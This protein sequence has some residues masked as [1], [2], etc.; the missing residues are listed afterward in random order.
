MGRHERILGLPIARFNE[1]DLIRLIKE[2]FG[3]SPASLGIGDDCCALRPRAGYDLLLTTDTLAEGV[4]FDRSYSSA[5][6]LGRK[7]VAVNLSDIAAMGGKP[8]YLLLSLNLTSD[9]DK[10]W[11]GK[12]LRGFESA[13][14]PF[15]TSLI[16]GN[17]TSA[18]NDL[19]FTVTAIGEVKRGKRVD[20]SGAKV[21]DFIYVTGTVGDSAVGLDILQRGSTK[22]NALEKRLITR[23]LEPTPRIEWGY[24]LGDKKLVSSMID[25][26]DGLAL[27]LSRLIDASSAGAEI[28]LEAI[29][30]SKDL[31]VSSEGELPW[32]R[33]L[34]GGEDY[35]LLFTVR[36]SA[37][38]EVEHLI[39]RGMLT[40]VSIGRV[41]KPPSG[42]NRVKIIDSSGGDFVLENRGWFHG[43]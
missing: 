4:H 14:N 38:P 43:D 31:V 6:N 3:D 23:H 5:R 41:T 24:L 26:S 7:S 13:I 11:I 35:E 15:D 20:R 1:R 22:H 39:E 33:I 16:G 10:R 32:E 36:P 12:Y 40:A 19:A 42:S 8:L 25:V 34:A 21:G 9:I 17:V 30:L 28:D 29:P 27:D 2:R 37:R 18:R